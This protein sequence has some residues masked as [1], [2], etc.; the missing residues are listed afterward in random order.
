MSMNM[1]IF[2][3]FMHLDAFIRTQEVDIL[4]MGYEA[5][6]KGF[7][8]AIFDLNASNPARPLQMGLTCR[9]I[10]IFLIF[11]FFAAAAA[12]AQAPSEARRSSV[13]EKVETTWPGVTSPSE[14]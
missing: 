13:A 14:K 7:H 9:S 11:F 1:W 4:L 2:Y 12:A 3:F 8:C 5:Q 10:F 6:A